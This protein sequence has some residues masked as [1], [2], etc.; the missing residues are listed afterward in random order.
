MFFTNELLSRRDSGF[1]LLWLAATLGAK[2]SFRKLPRRSVMTADIS[3]LCNLIAEPAEPLALRLSSNLMIGVARVYKVKQEILLTDVTSCFNTL[4]KATHDIYAASSAAAQLQMGQPTVRQALIFRL[5]VSWLMNDSAELVTAIADPVVAFALD[6]DHLFGGWDEPMGTQLNAEDDMEEDEEEYD[7]KSGR[8]TKRKRVKP[9][10]ISVA[11]EARANLHIL[12]E[13]HS[14]LLSNSLVEDDQNVGGIIPSSSQFGGFQFGDDYL[15]GVD[16]GGD[17][18]DELAKELGD[19]WGLSQRDA[20]LP[21]QGFQD[22]EMADVNGDM[23]DFQLQQDDQGLQDYDGAAMLNDAPS[24]TPLSA[25]R[26]GMPAMSDDFNGNAAAA[27]AQEG[28]I[29]LPLSPLGSQADRDGAAGGDPQQKPRKGKRVRLLLDARTELTNE[30]LERA[31]ANYL[32]GQA[33]LKREMERRKAEKESARLIEEMIWGAPRGVAAPVLVDFWQEN[34]RVQVEARSGR[35]HLITEGE[36]PSKRRRIEADRSASEG[37]DVYDVDRPAQDANLDVETGWGGGGNIDAMQD[38][39]N[40]DSRMRSSEEPGQGR[41][42]SRPPSI[43][44]SQFYEGDAAPAQDYGSGSQRSNLFPWDNAGVSSS[45]SSA[46]VPAGG[47][48]DRL[49]FVRA[50]SRLRGSSVDHDSLTAG[51]VPP[52][53]ASFGV[54]ASHRGSGFEFDVPA[55]DVNADDSQMTDASVLTLER[56]SFNFLEYARQQLNAAPSATSSLKFS[57]VVPTESTRHVAAAA[58]YHCL[59][60]STKDLLKVEQDESYSN[61][62]ITIR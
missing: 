36:P 39:W 42:A 59:V 44:G 25:K 18:G 48:S 7:P 10:S 62:E 34:F 15:D 37:R 57:D 50:D 29:I 28:S 43:L 56:N 14:Y 13:D 17:I 6:F 20:P 60:L 31:R 26:A 27:F 47:G 38:D 4:K 21:S 55:G 46:A 19:D 33:V 11:E 5:Q 51:F 9:S 40:V 30:E 2:S 23:D 35:L 61:I 53:P 54:S 52:S 8:K 1:G 58:F 12:Q 32:E 45:V 41:R 3:E 16:L 49:S 22:I 24:S